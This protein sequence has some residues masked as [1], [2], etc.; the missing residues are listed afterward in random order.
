MREG[1]V[2]GGYEDAVQV[3]PIHLSFLLDNIHLSGSWHGLLVIG[4]PACE[5]V[6]LGVRGASSWHCCIG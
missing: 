1:E 2:N 3:F 6:S 5:I 4:I